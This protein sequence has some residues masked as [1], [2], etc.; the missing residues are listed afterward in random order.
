MSFAI[1]SSAL[2]VDVSSWTDWLLTAVNVLYFTM[3]LM[4]GVVAGL[5]SGI[6]STS[7]STRRAV[8][9]GLGIGLFGAG[10]VAAS[11]KFYGY[12]W[13]YLS[14]WW[15]EPSQMDLF[16]KEMREVIVILPVLMA[17][18]TSVTSFMACRR[19]QRL[20]GGVKT[21]CPKLEPSETGTRRGSGFPPARE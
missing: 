19:W 17:V 4:T 18:L 12:Y 11:T 10:I 13:D 6:L 3:P 2:S 15:F 9:V 1:A 21:Y 14:G 5:L 20:R 7:I 16:M 8:L